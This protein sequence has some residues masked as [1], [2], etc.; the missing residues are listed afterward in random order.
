MINNIVRSIAFNHIYKT[1]YSS[2]C[3]GDAIDAHARLTGRVVTKKENTADD[4][5]RKG[6]RAHG[7][8]N[9]IQPF[10]VAIFQQIKEIERRICRGEF[11]ST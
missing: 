10:Q 7:T 2:R 4:R 9:S 1:R 8:P 3:L 5:E 11:K 6:V